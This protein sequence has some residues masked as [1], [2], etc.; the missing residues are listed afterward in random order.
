M[1][2][3]SSC[4]IIRLCSC[5]QS[6]PSAWNLSYFPP[7]TDTKAK[8][9]DVSGVWHL[10]NTVPFLCQRDRPY[11]KTSHVSQHDCPDRHSMLNTAIKHILRT[12]LFFLNPR[13]L[14]LFSWSLSL[15]LSS[16]TIPLW[17]QSV[18]SEVHVHNNKVTGQSCTPLSLSTIH[19]CHCGLQNT[20]RLQQV[21]CCRDSSD[22]NEN[23]DLIYSSSCHSKP[24]LFPA[25]CAS[26]SFTYND[27]GL[28]ALLPS[29]Y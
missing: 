9:T 24:D 23:S 26:C 5:T 13:P 28:Q 15:H 21:L 3:R 14:S 17:S 2:M 1:P 10:V 7:R 20:F 18:K 11:P 27:S 29:F 19:E 6:C 8:Q 25:E 22:K 12:W 16:L 4:L